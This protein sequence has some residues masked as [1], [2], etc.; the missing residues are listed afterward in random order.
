MYRLHLEFR[1]DMENRPNSKAERSPDIPPDRWRPN[2]TLPD[3]RPDSS[4][5][6][7]TENLV[8]KRS[9]NQWLSP[10]HPTYSSVTARLQ[11]FK[12]WPHGNNNN[13]TPESLSEAGF[14]YNRKYKKS[15]LFN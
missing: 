3:V 11:S 14:F 5:P 9:I 1:S 10:R 13:P 4:T 8:L 15:T 2:P 7:I 6:A 12:N